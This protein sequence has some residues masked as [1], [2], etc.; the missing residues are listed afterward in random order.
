MNTGSAPPSIIRASQYNA[1]LA[2]E[3]RTDLIERGDQIVVVFS[4]AI[5]CES[6]TPERLD[7]HDLRDMA[8]AVFPGERRA[9]GLLERRQRNPCVSR[10]P[11]RQLFDRASFNPRLRASE[12][13]LL[14]F[15][16]PRKNRG[17]VVRL[18]RFED[19]DPA[20]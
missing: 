16:C 5:I 17:E 14:V 4:L 11:S 18:E 19:H 8:A 1:A 9:H 12:P 6:S 10:R 7:Q 15:Q 2:S 13:A 3:F 20:A